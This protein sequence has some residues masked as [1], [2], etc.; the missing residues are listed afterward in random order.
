[1]RRQFL[2]KAVDYK[3]TGEKTSVD[4][5][6]FLSWDRDAERDSRSFSFI[7]PVFRKSSQKEQSQ[8]QILGI[9]FGKDLEGK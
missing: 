7:G 4:A 5:F 8:W 9:K 2:W 3:R 1:V 6:P